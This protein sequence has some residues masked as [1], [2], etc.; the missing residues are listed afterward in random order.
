M[1]TCNLSFV[2]GYNL[3]KKRKMSM[4]IRDIQLKKME[5]IIFLFALT[6]L[7]T[8]YFFSVNFHVSKD[9]FT[10]AMDTV[11]TSNIKSFSEFSLALSIVSILQGN[12]SKII[13]IS[14][15]LSII[16]II[17]FAFFVKG[18]RN[19]SL[20]LFLNLLLF[21]V[22]WKPQMKRLIKILTICFFLTGSIISSSMEEFRNALIKDPNLNVFDIN[23]WDAFNNSFYNSHTDVGMDLGNAALGIDFCYKNDTYNYGLQLWN[24]FVYNYIPR[25]LIGDKNKKALMY[26]DEYID[27]NLNSYWTH[28]VTTV[29]GYADA[30]S[31][32]SFFGFILFALVGYMYGN[33][34]EYSF[35][36]GFWRFV[37]LFTI[38]QIPV[39]VTHNLQFFLARLELVFIF[40]YPIVFSFF[41]YK[42]RLK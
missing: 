34:W 3:A 38:S 29:T 13:W 30:F 1:I 7:S 6:G 35:R 26:H 11:L 39:F 16:P 24:G 40:L 20:V 25:R 23:Y 36:S 10:G 22:L 17:N 5:W 8:V 42:K 37:Y 21:W 41:I 9:E 18:S 33:I 31:S 28:G 12:K 2:A 19:D 4:V 32:F 14:F 15:I 27:R